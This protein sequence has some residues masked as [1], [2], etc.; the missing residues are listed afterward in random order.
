[1]QVKMNSAISHFEKLNSLRTSRANQYVSVE[2]V[3]VKLL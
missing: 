2:A 3:V 1:M